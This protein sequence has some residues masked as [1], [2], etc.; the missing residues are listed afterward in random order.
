MGG[1]MSVQRATHWTS[2]KTLDAETIARDV[3]E[4][5]RAIYGDR[6]RGVLLFGSW[7]RGDAG[8]E[9]DI[10][11]LVVLDEV[12]SRHVELARMNDVLW[13]HSLENDTIVTE[14]PVSEAE[15]RDSGEPLIVRVRAEG[16]LV[17]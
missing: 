5:L 15:Y 8:P 17:A 11:L 9:S 12:P 6:L 10:D 14:I 1:V 7:A 3:A 13:R 2:E 16:T 4:D